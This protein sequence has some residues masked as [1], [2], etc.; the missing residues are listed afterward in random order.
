MSE[1]KRSG[2]RWVF[3]DIRGASLAF[4]L[5]MVIVAA[6]LGFAVVISWVALLVI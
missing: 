6:L 1:S 3:A 4:V 5:E 2:S